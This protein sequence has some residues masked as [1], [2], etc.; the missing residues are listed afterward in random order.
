MARK[1]VA[2]PSS[3]SSTEPNKRRGNRRRLRKPETDRASSEEAGEEIGLERHGRVP[4][5]AKFRVLN[6]RIRILALRLRASVF[7]AFRWSVVLGALAGVW[8]GYQLLE[9]HARTSP[10][11]TVR[12]VDLS[13]MSRVSRDEL[14]RWSEIHNQSNIFDRSNAQIEARLLEHPWVA[15]ASVRRDLPDALV[16][17]VTEHSPL[18]LILLE[19]PYLFSGDGDAFK[20]HALGDPSDLP[21]ITGV[22]ADRLRKEPGYGRELA[23][24]VEMLFRAYR[25]AGLWRQEPIGEIHFEPT[26][27]LRLVV[28]EPA[29]EVLLGDGLPQSGLRQLRRVIDDMKKERDLLAQVFVHEPG[30]AERR[31]GRGQRITVRYR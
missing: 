30:A 27:G 23:Q 8:W 1:P 22:D 13:G 29:M 10:T 20:V 31:T 26:G 2:K 24:Q 18:A 15:T 17:D 6:E 28:G 14:L 25:A 19:A 16:I 4:L 3:D 12:K 21:V 9:R 7:Q 5:R 11:F